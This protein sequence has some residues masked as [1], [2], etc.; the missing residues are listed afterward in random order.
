MSRWSVEDEKAL[1]KLR[2]LLSSELQD[3]PNYIDVIGDR[4]LI[5]FL[6]GFN[7][8]IDKTYKAYLV[9]LKWRKANNVNEIRNLILYGG[10]NNPN[11]FPKGE[12]ILKLMPQIVLAPY[13]FD[14]YN[15]PITF[16]I[17]DFDPNIVL[18]SITVSD[19]MLFLTYCVEYRSLYIEQ[20][21]EEREK[22]FLSNNPHILTNN[23]YINSDTATTSTN[24]TS[25]NSYSP[26]NS[27]NNNNNNNNNIH[28][29]YGVTVKL[30][31]L[32]DLHGV[33]FKT[34]GS[35]SMSIL[36][37]ALELAVPNYPEMLGRL[38]TL[39]PALIHLYALLPNLIPSYLLPTLIPNAYC[40]SHP[41]ISP[42]LLPL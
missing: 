13:H 33:G 10:Y 19:Y 20:I 35:K 17:F 21:S 41:V 42:L 2:E 5:R 37:A 11:V 3:Y 29:P 16:D 4:K 25:H 9:F 28:E 1:I 12:L 31:C 40:P 34:L 38:Y 6:R 14:N 39:L 15:Q 22:L 26:N 18:Q 8:D 30:C 23:T 32:R 36:K 24:N 27:T 7:L